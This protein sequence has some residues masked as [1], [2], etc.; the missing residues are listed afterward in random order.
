MAEP[1]T[2]KVTGAASQKTAMSKNFINLGIFAAIY[3]VVFSAVGMTGLIPIMMLL[4]IAIGCFF[5]AIVVMAMLT[6]VRCFGMYAAVIVLMGIVLSL[7]GH[8]F[9]ALLS[10]VVFG[11]LGDFVMS[12]GGY[13]NFRLN[14]LGYA[15]SC[16]WTIGPFLSVLTDP[17]GYW[18]SI[19]PSFGQGYVDAVAPL[20]SIPIVSGVVASGVVAGFLGCY[21]ARAIL[22]KHFSRAGIV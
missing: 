5:E 11:L 22:K 6:R 2:K 17:V 7:S 1:S 19:A 18:A 21:L 14:Q 16:L 20:F 10:A 12:R 13:K 4:Y 8:G 3:I 9:Y 15:I